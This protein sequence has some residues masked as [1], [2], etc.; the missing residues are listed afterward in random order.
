M[1]YGGNL[2]VSILLFCIFLFFSGLFT[3]CE[4]AIIAVSDV[5][6]R[7]LSQRD[8]QKAKRVLRITDQP[9]KFLGV[10]AVG[11]RTNMI[12]AA[13]SAC[14]I[15]LYHI[16][17]WIDGLLPGAPRWVLVLANV[18]P[19]ILLTAFLLL[20]FG[21]MIPRK[22]GGMK[23]ESIAFA[24]AGLVRFLNALFTP[25]YY[26]C[27]GIAGLFLRLFGIDPHTEP[28]Q[29]TEEEIRMMVDVGNEKG[30]IEESEKDMINN[31]FE[32]DDRTAEEVMTHRTDIIAVPDDAM[33]SDVIGLAMEEGFS[34]IPV[35]H[36][37]IDNIV[38]AVYV[39]DLLGLIGKDD[40]S[41]VPVKYYIRDVMYVPEANRC[42][43]LFR[44]FTEKKAHMAVVVDEYGGTSG[45]VTMEDL[46]ES[47]VGNIQDEYDNEEEEF[48]REDETTFT[49]DGSAD[50]EDVAKMLDIEIAETDD[51]D[52]LGGLITDMLGRIP[53]EEEHPSVTV[54]GVEFT[55]LLVEDRRIAKV[56]A[57]KLPEPETPDDDGEKKDAKD[58]N[59]EKK[60]ETEPKD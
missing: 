38:G 36:E 49:I 31:V 9:S 52:T 58:R 59:R 35:Y 15:W 45:L 11:G 7:Q 22:L 42:K 27:K 56:R 3:A 2:A 46:L 23:P 10:V 29:V 54:A 16:A 6:L 30:V 28:E 60:E 19:L 14:L 1:D 18:L 51:Y 13:V 47:I 43:D 37:D 53:S 48:C 44:E 8:D 12:A 21:Q 34:R 5:K 39:K 32:F 17:P 33:L 26:I 4:A 55:V 50:L 25:L 40:P 57:V 41:Q 20:V 24:T